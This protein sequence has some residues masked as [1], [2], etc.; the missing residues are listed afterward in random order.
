MISTIQYKFHIWQI[1]MKEQILDFLRKSKA[2]LFLFFNFPL[3]NEL[4]ISDCAEST[5][6]WFPFIGICCLFWAWHGFDFF[7]D[8]G[9][10]YTNEIYWAFPTLHYSPSFGRRLI[11]NFQV[12]M[13]FTRN[14]SPR[15]TNAIATSGC[16]FAKIVCLILSWSTV[17]HNDKRRW[18]LGVYSLGN[19]FEIIFSSYVNS[20]TCLLKCKMWHTI[21]FQDWWWLL[22]MEI[23]I[24]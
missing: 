9:S 22:M 15:L 11:G 24:Q 3:Y 20:H 17:P 12:Y 7:F 1:L 16:S 19:F 14:N 2:K 18:I 4:V 5:I 23:F 8:I 10:R 6:T 13:I 21:L